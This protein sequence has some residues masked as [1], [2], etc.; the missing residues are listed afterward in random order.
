M[1]TKSRGIAIC[2]VF[3]IFTAPLG[4]PLAADSTEQRSASNGKTDLAKFVREIV[5]ANPTVNAALAELDASWAYEAASG[6]PLYNPE[7]IFEAEDAESKTRA[8]GLSQTIDWGGKRRA[9][10]TVAEAER[11]SVE[12]DVSSVRWQVTEHAEGIVTNC[13]NF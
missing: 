3:L 1:S 9:R 6:R 8:L 11:R 5:D 4:G 2:L 10:L 12:A 7:L 13:W